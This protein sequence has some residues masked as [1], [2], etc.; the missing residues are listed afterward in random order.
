MTDQQI[1]PIMEINRG[2]TIWRYHLEHF[3]VIKE[4]PD[5]ISG[6]V[7]AAGPFNCRV[8]WTGRRSAEQWNRR[9]LT[10]VA[11]P[12]HQAALYGAMSELMDI[13]GE[14]LERHNAADKAL[15]AVREMIRS[16]AWPRRGELP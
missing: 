7:T 2:D 4:T 15:A 9:Q 1:Q 6:T 13:K 10:Q 8:H 14:A 16:T 5:I 3:G 12:S 11:Y